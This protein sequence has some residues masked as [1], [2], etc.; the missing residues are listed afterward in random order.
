M[1]TRVDRW[2]VEQFA[3]LLKRLKET[4]D[5]LGGTLLDNT[6]VLF[7]NHMDNGAGHGVEGDIPMILGGSAGGHFKTGRYLRWTSRLAH[8][9]LLASLAT[10]VG[11]PTASF[12]DGKYNTTAQI[13]PRLRG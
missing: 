5:P 10:A 12:G 2:F 1:K 9:G 3:Y 7:T 13:E 8:N 11:V 6:V 4:S